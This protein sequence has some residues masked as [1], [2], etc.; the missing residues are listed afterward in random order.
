V[1]K[2]FAQAIGH[3]CAENHPLAY[4]WMHFY[5]QSR[6]DG[7]WNPLALEISDTLKD[8]RVMFSQRGNLSLIS[9]VSILPDYFITSQDVALVPDTDDDR[10]LSD[11]YSKTSI[12]TLRR[13]DLGLDFL[14]HD[15]ILLRIAAE[16][17]EGRIYQRPLDDSWHDDF[18]NALSILHSSR[19][20]SRALDDLPIIPL[21]DGRWVSASS[22]SRTRVYLPNIISEDTFQVRIPGGLDF[23]VLH[24][25][26]SSVG[27]RLKFYM[28]L[29]VSDCDPGLVISKIYEKHHVNVSRETL[30]WIADLEVLFW[31]D[32]PRT[33]NTPSRYSSREFKGGFLALCDENKL[34]NTKKVFFPSTEICDAQSLLSKS[35]RQDYDQYGILD[36]RV[37][38][39]RMRDRMRAGRNWRAWL[40]DRG[41]SN[42]LPLIISRNSAGASGSSP[43]TSNKTRQLHPLMTLAARDNSA[44]F[45]DSLRQN[46]PAY[47][48]DMGYVKEE[49]KGSKVTCEDGNSRPLRE[50]I[51]PTEDLL[52]KSRGLGIENSLPFLR[53][54][55]RDQRPVAGDWRMLED[56]N[57]TCEANTSFYLAALSALRDDE[58]TGVDLTP[59]VTAVYAG[60]AYN[61]KMQDAP[62]L[63][64]WPS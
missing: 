16:L 54:P 21:E 19:N 32:K 39:S 46:W 22:L 52:A 56:L 24:I 17:R 38:G 57:V 61:S 63:T 12:E 64:V 6:M 8:L 48:Y 47:Q 25:T 3:L 41:I 62:I 28:S 9:H 15:M 58:R 60:L 45:I 14:T 53:L 29:G 23:Q 13:L 10:Y 26:A 40:E 5:P 37:V 33:I 55:P 42:C 7:F 44:A 50:T 59:R 4:H 36:Q 20:S 11:R 31:F 2:C 35:P 34:R 1:A 43:F 49:I 51:L 27:E 30:D 18:V